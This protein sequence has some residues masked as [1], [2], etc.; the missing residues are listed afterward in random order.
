MK[1]NFKYKAPCSVEYTYKEVIKNKNGTFVIGNVKV[2]GISTVFKAFSLY[3][4]CLPV[5]EYYLEV[6]DEPPLESEDLGVL[7]KSH[8]TSHT[9]T[10]LL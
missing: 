5:G 3:D 4:D 9:P 8:T 6:P 7:G 10:T 1:S 2:K